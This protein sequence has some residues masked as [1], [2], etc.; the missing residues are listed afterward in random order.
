MRAVFYVLTLLLHT[1]LRLIAM[2]AWHSWRS[3]RETEHGK[4]IY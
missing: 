1:R 2:E 3:R 4:E